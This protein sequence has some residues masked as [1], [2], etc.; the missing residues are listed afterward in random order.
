M[1]YWILGFV[2]FACLVSLPFAA[3]QVLR[4]CNNAHQLVNCFCVNFLISL[5]SFPFAEVRNI[6]WNARDQCGFSFMFPERTSFYQAVVNLEDRDA[7]C[8]MLRHCVSG[9]IGR[10]QNTLVIP[11]PLLSGSVKKKGKVSIAHLVC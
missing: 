3:L 7:F 9:D 6:R 4:C 2:A 5:I 11:V 8:T 1:Q 10:A